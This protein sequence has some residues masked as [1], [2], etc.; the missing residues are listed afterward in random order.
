VNDTDESGETSLHLI[1]AIAAIA[2][3]AGGPRIAITPSWLQQRGPGPYV[4]SRANATYVLDTNVTTSGT[5]F[6]V[7]APGVTLN[8]N[9]FTVTYGNTA[10]VSV[11]NGSFETG[12]GTN[13]PGWNI[14]GAPAAALAPNT[15][16][17]FGDQVLRL[18]NFATTQTILSNS[19]P[20]SLINHTYEATITPGNMN[21]VYGTAVT[22]SVVDTVTGRVLGTGSSANTQ[23]GFSAI[24]AFTPTTTHPVEIQVVVTPPPGVTTSIDLDAAT[25]NVSYDYGIIASG[26]W[27]GDMPGS[28]SGYLNLPA[29]VQSLYYAN[30]GAMLSGGNFTLKNGS[31]AQGQG[32]GTNSSPLF[33]DHLSGIT[34]DHVTCSATGID[35][36]NLDASYA[37]GNITVS[38]STFQDNI[39][40]VADRMAGPST[41]KFYKTKGNVRIERNRVLGSPQIGISVDTNNGYTVAINDNHISQN[42]MVANAY[43]IAM[44]ADSNFEVRG[45]TIVPQSGEGIVVDAS[46]PIPSNNGVIQNNYVKVQER[47]NRETGKNTYA[48]ALRLRNDVDSM[49]PQTNIDVSGNTFIATNGP[50]LSQNA[51]TVWI[52]YANIKGAMNNANVN[53]HDNIVEAIANTTDPSYHAY[54]LDLDQLDPGVNL[55]IWNNVLASN[56]ISLGLGGYNDKNV[57]GVTFIGNTLKKLTKVPTRAYTGIQAGADVT[58]LN[59]VRLLNTRLVDGATS[60]I[61]WMGTATKNLEVGTVLNLRVNNPRGS[62]NAGATVKVF[63]RGG[64]TLVYQGVTD[65]QGNLSGVPLILTTHT[66]PGTDPRAITTVSN[67]PFTIQVTTTGTR[68]TSLNMDP[69][70]SKELS[71]QMIH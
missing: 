62:P 38:N 13:V 43:A 42:S 16:Y 20:I 8:L 7:G 54:A 61:V 15:N 53:L 50:G 67:G 17:L 24:A 66:Q 33:F 1:A 12:S 60:E 31:I 11:T 14:T 45:N 35:T 56:D 27:W 51:Y 41:I 49:G 48:R 65:R 69:S 55:K 29:S 68:E 57:N 28:G 39:V 59:S 63:G 9:G 25:L 19:I 26:A 36:T 2:V 70:S 46:R 10:P 32:D 44:V 52:T 23:R 47:P 34:V 37:A 71:V 6:V 22:I 18:P 40:N 5:A 64:H 3:A 30:T 4:L 58:Q 21:M